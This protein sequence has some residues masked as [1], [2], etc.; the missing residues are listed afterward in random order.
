MINKTTS[1]LFQ[2]QKE[3]TVGACHDVGHMSYDNDLYNRTRPNQS[4]E[5][6]Y[7]NRKE[8]TC[9]ALFHRNSLKVSSWYKTFVN[10]FLATILLS[11]KNTKIL[12]VS[13]KLLFCARIRSRLQ[14]CCVMVVEE[15]PK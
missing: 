7:Q 5:S 6:W 14:F 3:L 2:N 8:S 13:N 10:S 15:G 9:S 4:I 11:I 12:Q 1:T